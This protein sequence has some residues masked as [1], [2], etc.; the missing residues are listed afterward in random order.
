VPGKGIFQRVNG[1]FARPGLCAASAAAVAALA[2]SGC[3]LGDGNGLTGLNQGSGSDDFARGTGSPALAT[4][5][6]IRIPGEDPVGDAAGAAITV[7]PAIDAKTRPKTVAVVG[8]SDWR[9][10]VAMSVLA[11]R[12][13]GAPVLLSENDGVP[14][15]TKSAFKALS[16]QGTQIPGL[17]LKPKAIVAGK[18]EVPE[19][20]PRINLVNSTYEKLSLSIDAL[21]TRIR[22]GKPTRS[23][24]VTSGDPAFARF[25][26]PAGPLSAKTGSPIFFVNRDIVPLETLRAIAAHKRPRIYVIGP[27]R[28]ISDALLKRLKRYGTVRRV[29]GANPTENAAA[30]ATYSDPA[31]GWGWGI[32]NPGHGMV[33]TNSHREMDVAAATSLSS[34]AAFG[35][36]LLNSNPGKIDKALENF[37]LDIQPGYI[38]DPSN[39]VY[40]RAWLLGDEK[41]LS[42]ALQAKIDALCE[43]LPIKVNQTDAPLP[44]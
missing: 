41:V 14:D 36:L 23:V 6:T 16:P 44:E 22:G 5:N 40:N 29:A 12:P 9:G 8:K 35:P 37:L 32:I 38:D 11:A 3:S 15:V 43:I 27:P 26:I 4:K 7:Y 2:L 39:G 25:S 31:T 28:V 33:V 30:V 18:V 1:I 10:A 17:A 21:W 20:T 42:P 13:L 24:I 34:G 19:K